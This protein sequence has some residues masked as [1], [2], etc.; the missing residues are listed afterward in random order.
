MQVPTLPSAADDFYIAFGMANTI[1]T[2]T[3]TLLDDLDVGLA[4]AFDRAVSTTA[5][6]A[7]EGN[8]SGQQNNTLGFVLDTAYNWYTIRWDTMRTRAEFFVNGV[9]YKT[10]TTWLPSSSE[11]FNLVMFYNYR[12]ASAAG[13][14]RD[15]NVDTWVCDIERR[16]AS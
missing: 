15:I 6:L 10:A 9:R 14:A 12:V 4:F 7:F 16:D 13:A 11:G 5:M 3:A 2:Q 8:G 1:G